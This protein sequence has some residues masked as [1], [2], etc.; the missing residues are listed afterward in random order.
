MPGPE[1]ACSHAAPP[2]R[3][4]ALWTCF[5]FGC[6][7]FA[8]HTSSH[9]RH[10]TL[11]GTL[12]LRVL[13]CERRRPL[14]APGPH[15]SL[16]CPVRCLVASQQALGAA[17]ACDSG[18]GAQGTSLCQTRGRALAAGPTFSGCFVCK[19]ARPRAR[20]THAGGARVREDRRQGSPSPGSPLGGSWPLA[21]VCAAFPGGRGWTEWS[22]EASG[23]RKGI[24]K[25]DGMLRGSQPAGVPCR[26]RR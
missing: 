19:S 8:R 15:L 7:L 18:A 23:C 10:M 3:G 12:H 11:S 13:R 4:A 26:I 14:R 2:R 16:L 17:E 20:A 1:P 9:F 22:R 5:P 6:T 21:G 24:F 25:G